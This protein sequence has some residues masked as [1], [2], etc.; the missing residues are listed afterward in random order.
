MSGYVKDGTCGSC[1]YYEYQGDNTRGYCS[2]YRSYYYPDDSCSH[3]ERESQV[4]SGGGCFLT[5]ACCTFK[6]LPDD[7]QELQKLRGFRDTYLMRQEYGPELIKLYYADAPSIV[8]K[9]DISEERE[10]IYEYIYEEI[11]E[12]IRCIEEKDNS[13]AVI[14]YMLMVYK[15]SKIV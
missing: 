5:A 9:I 1:S 14:R 4:Y 2:Y 10:K 6:G 8:K 12:I 13:G 11:K 7:C 15:L 3:W